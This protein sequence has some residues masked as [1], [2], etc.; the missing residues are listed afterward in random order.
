MGC[1][2][3]GAANPVAAVSADAFP[4]LVTE[5][6]SVVVRPDRYIVAVTTDL[7]HATEHLMKA[8]T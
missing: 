2:H 8:L 7:H 5:G 4:G 6:A 3:C 1:S